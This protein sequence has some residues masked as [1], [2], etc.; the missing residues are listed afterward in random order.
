VG[1]A[2][3]NE[4]FKDRWDAVI[5][6]V[7]RSYV[8]SARP[9]ASQSIADEL[10]L[11][12]ATIRN[13]FAG[14][15]DKG[16]LT[17]PHTSAGRVPTDRCYRIYVDRLMKARD[18]N[19]RERQTIEEQYQSRR[20]E[21]ETL[22]RH[23]ARL[24]SAM[25]RL[26]GVGVAPRTL[27][28]QLD[29]FQVVQIDDRKIMVILVTGDGLV[30]EEL[31]RLNDPLSGQELDRIVHLLNHRFAGRTLSDIRETLLGEAEETR[32]LRLAVVQA[33]LELIDR[34]LDLTGEGV[35]VEGASHL[36]R[37]PEFQNA[38]HAGRVLRLLEER[39]PLAELLGRQ[40][41]TPGLKIEI[42]REITGDGLSSFSVVHAPYHL[43]GRL[44]GVLAVVGPTRMPY[45][46]VILLLN[47]VCRQVGVCLSENA[48]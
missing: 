47:Q 13:V 27:D 28:V 14:L 24:L 23:S 19:L 32:R 7:V 11:S 1:V 29:H 22:I 37:Q 10:G 30:R 2:L 46:H 20:G 41:E 26:A 17:H 21:V 35:W 33:T 42:G 36:M 6:A 18:L 44:A 25:T 43:N 16:Y 15:E 40:W 34:T 45:D 5:G 31:V 9:V 38:D 8:D 12:S 4:G 48:E 3:E 39:Q